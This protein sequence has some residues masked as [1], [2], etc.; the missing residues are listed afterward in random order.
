[1][2]NLIRK[3]VKPETAFKAMEDARKGKGVKKY[4]E[5]LK[6]NNVDD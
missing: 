5:E 2:T 6:M 3:G 1:M 4:R